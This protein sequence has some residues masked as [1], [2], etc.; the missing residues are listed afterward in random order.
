VSRRGLL[1]GAA[2]AAVALA[3]GGGGLDYEL[4]RDPSLR[5]RLFGCGATKAI[6]RSTYALTSGTM[7]SAAMGNAEPW[8]VAL[9]PDHRPGEPLALVLVLPGLNGG[10]TDLTTGAGLPGF[11]TAARLRLAFACP[12]G[13]GSTYYHPRADGTNCFAW[14]TEEFLPMVETRFGVG[15]ARERRGVYGSSMGGFGALLI[16]LKRP[17]LVSAVAASSPAVFPSYHAAITGHPDT[18]DSPADWA[19]WG[20]W[21]QAA[22]MRDVAVW[23]DCGNA[24]PFEPTARALLHRIP[25]AAGGISSGCHLASFW[26]QH[27][28]TQL[29]FLATHLTD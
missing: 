12:G 5:R 18:F 9:P 19:T 25:G 11:A 7:Q 16:G 4:H 17:D 21:E 22:T 13:A 8:L 15:G 1:I 14:I 23:I 20:F 10:P 3:A 28:T 29:H 27:A 26:R 2:G 6:P 24:D